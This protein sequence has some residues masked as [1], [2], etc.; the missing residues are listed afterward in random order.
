MSTSISCQTSFMTHYKSLFHER[1]NTNCE[2]KPF[3]PV[4]NS[5]RTANGKKMIISFQLQFTISQTSHQSQNY[6]TKTNESEESTYWGASESQCRLQEHPADERLK[7][8]RSGQFALFQWIFHE[9]STMWKARAD[10]SAAA[11]PGS[12]MGARLDLKHARG[13]DRVT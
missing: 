8:E 11:R 7:I 1:V 13:S 4:G 12:N 6:H 9:N 3:T 5:T 10:S 2:Q